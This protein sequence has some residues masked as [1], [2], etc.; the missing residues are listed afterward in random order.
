KLAIH[1]A[2]EA[3]ANIT[4]EDLI[5]TYTVED[6][7]EKQPVALPEELPLAGV[8]RAFSEHEFLCYPVVDDERT[9]VG[10]ISFH[11]I[12]STLVT[13][14]LH[15]LLLAHDLMEPAREIVV[16]GAPLQE[17]IDRME[18]LGL[19]HLAVVASSQD[20]RLVGFLDRQLLMHAITA[21]IVRRREKAG[22]AHA[23]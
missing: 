18:Q 7:M 14:D 1:R 17:T 9:L 16:P 11:Q 4:S 23:T 15:P 5:R 22:A 19:E 12:K 13:S 3:G 10:L 21:E 6:V 8:L 20:R 2:G